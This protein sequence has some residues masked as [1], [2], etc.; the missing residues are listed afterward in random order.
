[1]SYVN[2]TYIVRFHIIVMYNMFNNDNLDTCSTFS[3]TSKVCCSVARRFLLDV[4]LESSGTPSA[5][6]PIFR[7]EDVTLLALLET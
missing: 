3:S 7:I 2:Y 1:M 5:K 6:T 4:L